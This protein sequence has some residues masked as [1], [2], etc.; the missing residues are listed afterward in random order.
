MYQTEESTGKIQ[1][2]AYNRDGGDA[3]FRSLL[4]PHSARTN[5]RAVPFN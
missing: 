3:R 1:Y 5:L 4:T 2:L